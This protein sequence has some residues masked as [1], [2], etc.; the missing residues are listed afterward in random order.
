[1]CQ[2]A[3]KYVFWFHNGL[4]LHIEISQKSDENGSSRAK[5]FYFPA[6]QSRAGLMR[7]SQWGRPLIGRV[8]DLRLEFFA[9]MA[10]DADSVELA[11]AFHGKADTSFAP[12][13]IELPIATYEKLRRLA[14]EYLRN[15]RP[16][17]T[18]QPT[19]LLHEAFLRVLKRPDH[20]WK[21]EAH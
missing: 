8:N 20:A 18:L 4:F 19:A 15:E 17:H 2:N 11:P 3:V 5:F 1:N 10:G 12:H 14:A 21:N 7:S 9:L 6:K 13:D 16:D